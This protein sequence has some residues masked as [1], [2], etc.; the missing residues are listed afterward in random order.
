MKTLE[1]TPPPCTQRSDLLLAPRRRLLATGLALPLLTMAWTLG[2][3]RGAHAGEIAMP[4]M[5]RTLDSAASAM[6]D[7]AETSD[8][9]AAAAAIARAKNATRDIGDLETPFVTSGGTLEHF[10]EVQNN[11]SADL[12]EAETATSMKDQRW[13]VS[14]ADH[15]AARAGELSEPFKPRNNAIVSRVDT[16]LFLARR[17]RRARVWADAAGYA[18]ASTAFNRLWSALRGALPGKTAPQTKALAQALAG[19]SASSSSA[20][21]RKLYLAVTALE[22]ALG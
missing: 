19:I 22:R 2:I 21:L 8:W 10:F 17:M 9:A 14:A 13:L 1:P 18:D 3:P 4:A 7:A 6:F 20:D 11:L 5:V 12:M 16:L 15:L